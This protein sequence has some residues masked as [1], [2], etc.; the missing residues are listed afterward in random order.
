MDA[1]RSN[2]V[3]LKDDPVSDI[4]QNR[5]PDGYTW[6]FESN[7]SG[8]YQFYFIEVDNPITVR[9]PIVSKN[10]GSPSWSRWENNLKMKSRPTPA[11]ADGRGCARP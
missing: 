7:R 2:Q 5:L 6:V 10:P 4:S 3:K 9:I 1:D 11:P 8:S